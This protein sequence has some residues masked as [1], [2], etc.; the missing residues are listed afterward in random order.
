MSRRLLVVVCVLV[1][2]ALVA[3]SVAMAGEAAPKAKAPK[4]TGV[5]KWMVEYPFATTIVFLIAATV[6][7]S[8]ISRFILDRCLKDFE[9]Y[10]VTLELKDAT[11]YHG[12]LDVEKS[13]LEFIYEK[14]TPQDKIRKTSFLIYQPE[15]KNVHCLVRY[16]DRLD[17][18]QLEARRKAADKAY[19]PSLFRRWWR[20]IRNFLASVKDSLL[21]AFKLAMGRMKGIQAAAPVMKSGGSYI[22]RVGKQTI[23]TA[24]D[25]SY[26]PLLEKQI[27][28]RVVLDLPQDSAVQDECVG[29]LREYTKD[30]FLLM[31]VDYESRWDIALPAAGAAAFV[32]GIAAQRSPGGIHIENCATFDI[33]LAAVVLQA[34]PAEGEEGPRSLP[35]PLGLPA[36]VPSGKKLEFAIPSEAT[37]ATLSFHTERRADLVVPRTGAFIRHKSEWV[38]P[39][40]LVGQL[41]S[42]VG[43]LPGTDRVVAVLKQGADFMT[44]NSKKDLLPFVKMHGCG[45]D[46]VYVDCRDRTLEEPGKL[47]RRVSDRHFGIGSDGLILICPS[48]VADY[49]MRMFNSDDG[50]E[51]EMCGN[52]LRCFAKYLYD[53]KLIRG[54]GARIETGAGVLRVEIFA[55]GDKAQRVRVNMGAPILERGDIPMEGPPGQ[56]VDEELTIEVPH[57]GLTNLR[58][59]AVSMGNPHAIIYVDGTEDYPVAVHGPLVENHRLFPRRINA[60]FVEVINRGECRMR[61][62]E[63]GAGETL[64]CGTGASAVCVAGVL[65]NKT[66][67]EVTVHLLGGDLEI[68]WAEDGCVYLTGPA[69][70]VFEGTLEL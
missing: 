50:S 11:V 56:A 20:A 70:E 30:F 15:Y 43:L 29:T 22:D 69:E 4:P 3:G 64:A 10:P 24:A 34:P 53:R 57:T 7:G 27:G 44:S 59:T 5:F 6:V 58:F 68:E 52:G 66:D 21:E 40:K 49:R 31:D 54:D 33:E 39:R 25:V 32:R 8:L 17:E 13:G 16:H 28:L 35:A 51:A 65:N 12:E 67:R 41:K 63:R 55:E 23:G 60:E 61:V 26:D 47:A 38:E 18:K 2:I 9:G 62:W 14:T 37:A 19:H 1:A 46:Y 36:T 42:A 48:E 45:N